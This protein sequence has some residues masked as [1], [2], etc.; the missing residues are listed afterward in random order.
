MFRSNTQE[1]G[2]EL[3]AALKD[4]RA[5]D[6]DIA[7]CLKHCASDSKSH[8][9]HREIVHQ[10]KEKQVEQEALTVDISDTVEKIREEIDG[11]HVVIKRLAALALAL[12]TSGQIPLAQ[13]GKMFGIGG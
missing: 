6:A 13:L 3:Q 10:V 5:L 11:F 2:A 8:D 7:K 1:L 9:S 4:I 12:L